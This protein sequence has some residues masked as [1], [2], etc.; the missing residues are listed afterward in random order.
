MNKNFSD[1]K[2]E[3]IL[4]VVSIFKRVQKRLTLLYVDVRKIKIHSFSGNY[5]H[6]VLLRV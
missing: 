6:F 4:F 1:Q 2:Y 3:L 5:F